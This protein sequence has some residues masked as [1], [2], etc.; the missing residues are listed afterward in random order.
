M[1]GDRGLVAER[2]LIAASPTQ[3]RRAPQT[4]PRV[5]YMLAVCSVT[6]LAADGRLGD[7]RPVAQQTPRA[8]GRERKD[9]W[10]STI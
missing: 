1:T 3:L 5:R 9:G 8:D 4:Q 10:L 2:R 6:T 7:E